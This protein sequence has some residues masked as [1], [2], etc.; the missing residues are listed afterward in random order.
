MHDYDAITRRAVFRNCDTRL[1]NHFSCEKDVCTGEK[2][3]CAIG[4]SKVIHKA[5]SLT[6][7]LEAASMDFYLVQLSGRYGYNQTEETH[8]Y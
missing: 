5:S 2:E 4:N 6:I 8:S 1:R 7:D 3:D